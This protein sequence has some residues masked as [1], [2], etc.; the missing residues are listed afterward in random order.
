[1]YQRAP[2]CNSRVT[3]CYHCVVRRKGT[4]LPLALYCIVISLLGWDLA[5]TAMGTAMEDGQ[6]PALSLF[7]RW[8]ILEPAIFLFLA[9]AR[10]V[11]FTR[12]NL[13]IEV[14]ETREDYSLFLWSGCLLWHGQHDG[15]H[16]Q[17]PHK[18]GHEGGGEG[19]ITW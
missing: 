16:V 12:T 2:I 19:A 18:G 3:K 7:R 5:T 15:G 10:M 17:E 9:S 4:A 11:Y 8:I 6:K 1:M 13:F 14:S